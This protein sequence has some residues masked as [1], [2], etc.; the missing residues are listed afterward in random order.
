MYSGDG[1]AQNLR[2]IE[3]MDGKRPFYGR[4]GFDTTY[5][6]GTIFGEAGLSLHFDP[7]ENTMLWGAPGVWNWTGTFLL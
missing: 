7:N 2:S 5:E 3:P 4:E 1:F 6:Y